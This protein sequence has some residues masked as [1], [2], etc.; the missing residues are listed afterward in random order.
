MSWKINIGYNY[1]TGER[2]IDSNRNLLTS[3]ATIAKLENIGIE[4]RKNKDSDELEKI[5]KGKKVRSIS[6]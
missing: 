1:T 2:R 3:R 6:G 4:Q 5:I